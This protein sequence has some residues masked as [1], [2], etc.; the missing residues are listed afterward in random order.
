MEEAANAINWLLNVVPQMILSP[1][2][3]NFYLVQAMW[4]L[5]LFVLFISF[6]A[7]F[8]FGRTRNW[9]RSKGG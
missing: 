6:F 5:I 7:L 3:P 1:E 9:W 8:P 2:S 4:G